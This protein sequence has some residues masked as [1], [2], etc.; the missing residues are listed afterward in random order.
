[1]SFLDK[2]GSTVK[3][4][5]KHEQVYDLLHEKLDL[6]I[7]NIFFVSFV[8]G[9][10]KGKKSEDFTAGRKEFRV[11]YLD[12]K[13]K[14]IMYTIGNE[15]VDG[16]FFRDPQNGDLIRKIIREYQLYATAGMDIIINEIF[17]DFSIGGQLNPTIADYDIE[18][19]KYLYDELNIAPF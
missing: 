6:E 7:H 11:T 9:Y 19:I 8:I 13:Q 18:F 17:D 1:M 15:M 5:V 12:E 10:L 4:D 3:A 14:S 16:E 2:G